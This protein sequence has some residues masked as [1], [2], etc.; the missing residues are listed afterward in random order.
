MSQEQLQFKLEDISVQ[1]EPNPDIGDNKAK[2]TLI[3]VGGGGCNMIDNYC[4]KNKYMIK[5]P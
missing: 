4:E 1:V 5:M 3:G 2:I